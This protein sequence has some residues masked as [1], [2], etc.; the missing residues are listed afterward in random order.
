MISQEMKGEIPGILDRAM[1]KG[2]R[3]AFL[4]HRKESSKMKDEEF[5]E[6]ASYIK[7]D[8]CEED[9]RRLKEGEFF[10]SAPFHYRIP[11][12]FSEKKRD[13]Y[14]W[15][16]SE[17]YLFSLIGYIMRDH[18]AIFSPCL[19]SFRARLSAQDFL[20]KLR[21]Y[22][23]IEKYYVVKA[24]VSNYV[25]SIVPEQILVRLKKIWGNDPAFYAI[26]ESLLLRR[27][28]IERDG[29]VVRCEPGGLGGNPLSNHFMNVYLMELDEYYEKRSPLYCRYSDDLIIFARTLE[30]ALE[31]RSYFL[32][33]LEEKHLTTNPEKTTIVEPGGQ[34]D[35]LGCCL[36]NG[37]MD[38]AEHAK[39]KLKRKIR[40]R[41]GRLIK[42]KKRYGLTDREAAEQMVAA[43]NGMFF[44]WSESNTLSWSRWLFPVITV[45]DSLK[46]LDHYAQDAI[47]HVYWGTFSGKQYRTRYADLKEMGYRSLVHAY[48]HFTYK[49]AESG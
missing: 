23:E 41:A 4:L 38:I 15:K 32:Q 31:Y 11:K 3:K 46:E 27:E 35:V 49:Y 5:E 1:S 12:N 45:T 28:C 24:D 26:L 20:K 13:L 33:T 39:N 16:G 30:E 43:C 48:Y 14:V 8:A 21:N 2:K 37:V 22:P 18:D 17:K 42:D 6:M 7:S 34:V 40:I 9:L 36:K 29:S 47:R 10:F 19:Y 44:G 25:S